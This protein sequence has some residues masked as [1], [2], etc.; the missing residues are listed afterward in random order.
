[1]LSAAPYV[2]GPP[3]ARLRSFERYLVPVSVALIVAAAGGLLYVFL[4]LHVFK[5]AALLV[6]G[7]P[8][9]VCAA[10][11]SF[12]PKLLSADQNEIR[13]KEPFRTAQTVQRWD[14]RIE[15]RIVGD[16][17]YAS[18]VDRT[19]T[20]RLFVG[21]FTPAQI[22]SFVSALGL[23]V[24]DVSE[25]PPPSPQLEAAAQ[26]SDA[27]GKRAYWLTLS[28]SMVVAAIGLWILVAVML[29]QYHQSLAAYQ[30]APTCDSA[31]RPN[32]DCRYRTAAVVSGVHTDRTGKPAMTLT[33]AADVF[34]SGP[35]RHRNVTLVTP[36]SPTPEEGASVQ[37]EV[38]RH[39]LIT[40]VNGTETSDFR[41]VQSNANDAWVLLALAGVALG[42]IGLFIWQWRS[43]PT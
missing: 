19:G 3:L 5:L 26:R 36:P 4:A 21:V 39:D 2:E 30:A 38:W 37:A 28:G 8:L 10:L 11:Q 22:A 25:P 33:F 43:K 23:P 17:S 7:V 12:L 15:Q 31:P 27:E 42:T 40:Q 6:L 14:V 20:E 41:T 1:M 24:R 9:A 18:F 34:T 16:S 32:Q 35:P 13:W 29:D